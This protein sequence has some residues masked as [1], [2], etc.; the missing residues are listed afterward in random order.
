MECHT[1][2]YQSSGE[3]KKQERIP[4]CG[5]SEMRFLLTEAA[6]V[7]LMKSKKWGK[8]KACGV[9]DQSFP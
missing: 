3:I 6:I 2:Q 1:T 5:S 9:L 8:L 4:R 7:F